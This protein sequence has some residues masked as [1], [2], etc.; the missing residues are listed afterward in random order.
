MESTNEAFRV[1]KAMVSKTK[2]ISAKIGKKEGLSF[3]QRYFIY[4]NQQRKDGTLF[5]KRVAV[6][7]SMKVADNRQVTTGQSEA[8]EFYKIF[9]GK[10]DNMGMFMEQKNDEGSIYFWAIPSMAWPD[11]RAEWN[12]LF[13][14]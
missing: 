8:S 3:D 2:P 11:I 6:V 13:Q 12:I 9:G 1:K 7:K 4:E 10:V 5:K 14:K